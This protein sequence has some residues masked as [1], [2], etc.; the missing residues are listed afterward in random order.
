MRGYSAYQIY[1]LPSR[2][3]VH[4]PILRVSPEKALGWVG[5]A[6]RRIPRRDCGWYA[7][8]SRETAFAEIDGPDKVFP[9]FC[10]HGQ[11]FE[12]A[13]HGALPKLHSSLTCLLGSPFE[14][15]NSP[16][17]AQRYMQ[18]HPSGRRP[19][20]HAANPHLQHRFALQ[21][22][23]FFL[24]WV[25]CPNPVLQGR[26]LFLLPRAG[27]HDASLHCGCTRNAP[28]KRMRRSGG[29]KPQVYNPRGRPP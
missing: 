15:G 11:A 21:T 14:V 12:E 23:D 10:P 16:I 20:P 4:H 24:A 25:V 27:A 3:C 28:S 2:L 22:P 17:F 7:A 19:I 26:A 9:S 18:L 1:D 13:N 6:T 5:A 8:S 29:E